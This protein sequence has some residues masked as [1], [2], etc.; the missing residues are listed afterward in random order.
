MKEAEKRVVTPLVSAVETKGKALRTALASEDIHVGPSTL[1]NGGFS[2]NG[3]M[4]VD[5]TVDGADI[6]AERLVISHIG[7][8]DG[9]AFVQKAEISGFFSGEL[10]VSDEVIIR[11][12]ARVCG[13]VRCDKLVIHRGAR[14]ECTFS[15]STLNAEPV[16]APTNRES[17]DKL[18]VQ[19]RQ[20]TDRRERQVFLMGAGSVLALIGCTALLTTLVATLRVM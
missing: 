4:I 20:T 2:T 10:V 17:L 15:C 14:V 7:T 13:T 1:L 16:D 11:P 3:M 5:G 6:S 12:T 19:R 18:V 8:V 9:R